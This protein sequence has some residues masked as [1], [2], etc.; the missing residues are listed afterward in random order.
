MTRPARRRP[1][2]PRRAGAIALAL[3][4]WGLPAACRSADPART[5]DL[6]GAVRVPASAFPLGGAPAPPRE[7]PSGAVTW[8]GRK[9]LP[10]CQRM[11]VGLVLEIRPFGGGAEVARIEER[12]IVWGPLVE[13]PAPYTV[14][15]GSAGLAPRPGARGLFLLR[16]L[17]G[18]TCE[19]VEISPLDDPDGPAR[20]RA[21]RRYLEIEGEADGAVRRDALLAY[22][23]GA[24]ADGDRWTREN[25]LREYGAFADAFPGSLEPADGA[26][27]ARALPSVRDPGLRRLVQAALDR[28]PATTSRTGLRAQPPAGGAAP[29]EALAPFTKRFDAARSDAPARRKAIV[30][31][32]AEVGAASAPLVAR[33]LD[34]KDPQVR[35]AAV[36]AAGV[37][38]IDVASGR[39]LSL[40][41]TDPS[42]EVRATAVRALG[43][44]R[45]TPAVETLAGLARGEPALAREALHALARIR[46]PA[47]LE[48]LAGLRTP[49]DDERRRLVDFLVSEAFVRQEKAMGARWAAGM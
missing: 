43:H 49:G 40:A 38:G 44:L 41:A 22:L 48:K 11:V 26:A 5:P 36:A 46:S 33:A 6:P 28:A 42:P 30:D 39:I 27:L 31:A 24:V 3:A 25:A 47:A 15:C 16:V 19:A 34:D 8:L 45:Y 20:L 18:G 29:A 13:N 21:F 37:T 10:Q 14:F 7:T 4:V 1:N 32:A 17:P 35:E 12:E 23:R 2:S 9:V